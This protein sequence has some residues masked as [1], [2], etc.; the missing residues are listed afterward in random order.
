[1]LVGV[2]HPSGCWPKLCLLPL[3]LSWPPIGISPTSHRKSIC[4]EKHVH[5]QRLK[6]QRERW[7][8]AGLS[9]MLL[10]G[11]PGFVSVA[12]QGC[13]KA[14]IRICV[15]CNANKWHNRFIL[16]LGYISSA[17]AKG[18]ITDIILHILTHLFFL[19][20]LSLVSFNSFLL[21][22]SFQRSFGIGADNYMLQWEKLY[23][24]IL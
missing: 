17:Q 4:W 18:I 2:P 19:I 21:T 13:S 20:V 11:K 10:G 1:M 6:M 8:F 5:W 15:H 7:V 12:W 14:L 22:S 16:C 24:S 9:T 23:I 3:C